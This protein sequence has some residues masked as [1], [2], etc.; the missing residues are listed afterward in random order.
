MINVTFSENMSGTYERLDEPGVLR[1][2][3]FHVD[4]L[5]GLPGTL[6]T[7]RVRASGHVEAE[8]LAEHAAIEGEMVMRPWVARFV[9]YEF[10]FTAD[11]GRRFRY[12]GQKRIR[13]LRPV[14]TWTTLPGTLFGPDGEEWATSVTRFDPRELASFLM[15]YRLRASGR[16]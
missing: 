6:L 7:G 1:P 12:A 4:A 8:D 13:H 5:G 10:A 16:P 2:F 11:D 15:S 9:R 3:R 14:S